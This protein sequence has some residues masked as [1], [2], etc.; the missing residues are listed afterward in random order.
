MEQRKEGR[1]GRAK[2]QTKKGKRYHRDGVSK[3]QRENKNKIGRK[4]RQKKG[5]TKGKEREDLG[6]I[7]SR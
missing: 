4:S 7:L 2:I 5:G 6:H 3:K 1:K